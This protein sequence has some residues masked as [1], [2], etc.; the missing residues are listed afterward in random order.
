MYYKLIPHLVKKPWGGDYYPPHDGEPVGELILASDMA[1]YPVQIEVD[2]RRVSFRDFWSEYTSAPFP[3]LLKILSIAKPLS[4]QVHPSDED[5]KRLGL[6]GN[7]KEEAWLVLHAKDN[8][9]AY[10]GVKD[11]ETFRAKAITGEM[12]TDL[13]YRYAMES[14]DLF[15]LSPG[16]V[17]GTEGEFLI[18][19]AQQPSMHTFRVYDFDRGREL[20]LD[21]ALRVIR[22]MAV[23]NYRAQGLLK[24][25]NF[26]LQTHRIENGFLSFESAKIETLT[27]LGTKAT[28]TLNESMTM[29][30]AYGDTIL[31]LNNNRTQMSIR[32]IAKSENN[33]FL[34]NRVIQVRK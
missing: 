34:N 1:E 28:I 29:E 21:Y 17:H 14:G 26:S 19:E 22:D 33:G 24:T 31:S 7:G 25:H 15:L 18:L 4:F 2:T 9:A 3:F 13:F 30:L 5:V 27:Y 16:L 23:R 10:L 12:T 20:H 6:Q 32:P 8:A 11:I